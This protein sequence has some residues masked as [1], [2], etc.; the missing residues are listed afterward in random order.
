MNQ[1]YI[2]I[3]E[4]VLKLR[5]E[6]RLDGECDL[7][8]QV[9]HIEHSILYYRSLK[10]FDQDPE[11]LLDLFAKLEAENLALIQECQEAEAKLGAGKEVSVRT[12][13]EL[14]QQA[15]NLEAEIRQLEGKNY[16]PTNILSSKDVTNH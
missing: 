5:E 12:R 14:N 16:R 15:E 2:D 3:L 11:E 13:T 8:F 1:T 9:K 4:A 6:D 7:Y 10:N